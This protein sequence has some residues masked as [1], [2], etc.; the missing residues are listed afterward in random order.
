MNI[1]SD[2]TMPNRRM[3]QT[4]GFMFGARPIGQNAPA[5]I[6]AEI[7]INH[8]G[9]A[10]LCARMIDMAARSGA[11]AI[12]LQ[13]VDP[14]SNYAIGSPSHTLF[15][16]AR[17]T[18]EEMD[19]LFKFA[20][21]QNVEPFTTAGDLKT[22]AEVDRLDPSGYKVSS[23]LLTVTPLLR[24]LAKLQK[25]IIL[26]SGMA[27]LEN[28]DEAVATILQEGNS[29]IALLQCTSLYPAP[30]ETL[31]LAVIQSFQD[32]YLCPCGYSDHTDAP[33]SAIVAVAAGAKLVEK[34]FTLDSNRPS[35]DHA[36]SLEPEEFARMVA[37]IR[38]VEVW[39]GNKTKQPDPRE[40][41]KVP[42]T[43]RFLAAARDIAAGDTLNE[44]DILFLRLL[45]GQSGLLPSSFDDV[46]GRKLARPL[47]RQQPIQ[48]TDL[49]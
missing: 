16:A 21:E 15:S 48:N 46:V 11:D 3:V 39:L 38:E 29:K 27:T 33:D 2:K 35:Y 18:I 26:S 42:V 47:V 5:F 6:I 4:D 28:I 7:G 44:D 25:P 9:D 14:D 36:I 45:P 12:K 23:G 1:E 8:E 37:R 49:V 20:R 19:G 31:N 30:P 17:L 43:R 22:L 40:L 32:R 34:H 10:E 13:T 24:A 41:A